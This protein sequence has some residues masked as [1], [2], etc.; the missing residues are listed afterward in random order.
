MTPS[1]RCSPVTIHASGPARGLASA[2]PAAAH[3]GSY[4]RRVPRSGE[5][6]SERASH[7]V[8]SAPPIMMAR[9]LCQH[10]HRARAGR[11]DER[12]DQR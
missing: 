6:P 7:A 8:E 4:G 12:V 2:R 1:V 9:G 3:S 10:D 5:T 11:H